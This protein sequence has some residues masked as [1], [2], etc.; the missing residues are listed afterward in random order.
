MLYSSAFTRFNEPRTNA[1][2]LHAIIQLFDEV[3]HG[4]WHGHS[5]AVRGVRSRG[6][7][8]DYRITFF[9]INEKEL[10]FLISQMNF[11]DYEIDELHLRKTIELQPFTDEQA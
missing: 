7:T 2:F 1:H 11:G 3:F 6:E 10:D 4:E 5:V 9:G 8:E